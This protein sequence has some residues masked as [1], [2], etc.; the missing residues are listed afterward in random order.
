M[1]GARFCEFTVSEGASVKHVMELVR[2]LINSV[3][4][5]DK[6]EKDQIEGILLASA[7]LVRSVV[8]ESRCQAT[9]KEFVSSVNTKRL[10]AAASTPRA[11]S[12]VIS[13]FSIV[14]PEDVTELVEEC[15]RLITC[16]RGVSRDEEMQTQ[17]RP[18]HKLLMSCDAFDH[19]F[20]SLTSILEKMTYRCHVKF[21]IEMSVKMPNGKRRKGESGVKSL[22]KWKHMKRTKASNFEEDYS[23]VVAVAWQLKELLAF[24]DGQKAVLGS[25]DLEH[26]FLALKDILEVTIL[27]A[28]CCD[29]MDAE[30]VLAYMVLSSQ[31]TLQSLSTRDIGDDS[32]S[33]TEKSLLHQTVDH[34]LNCTEQLLGQS[35]NSRSNSVLDNRKTGSNG[36]RQ[37]E[38]Q[39]DVCIYQT[40]M[41]SFSY[42]AKFLNLILNTATSNEA[43][44]EAFELTNTMFDL[45][46][47]VELH[48]GPRASSLVAAASAKP[49][50]PDLTLALGSGTLPRKREEEIANPRALVGL[51]RRD[52]G[53]VMGMLHFVCV[54]LVGEDREWTQ[55]NAMLT[56]LL[57]IF[58]IIERQ[59]EEEQNEEEARKESDKAKA[60]LEPG[61]LYHVYETG[62]FC[63]AEE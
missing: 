33:A 8:S 54:K 17:V 19:M 47:C 3:L 16:S 25:Q 13:I 15:M 40:M 30:P 24:V 55:L 31:R 23:I 11:Q 28:S 10:F 14:S 45:I 50:L 62:K 21:G 41:S 7:H 61:W 39:A 53:L 4:L 6:A 18:A 1:G 34:V 60:L 2:V 44:Q 29:Y 59:V 63:D 56:S 36:N 37:R 9:L 58:P 51:E 42:S 35:T 32:V 49:W 46:I 5:Q 43:L 38:H 22:A 26:A 57:E 48:F 52:S 12:S 27:Q 20:P